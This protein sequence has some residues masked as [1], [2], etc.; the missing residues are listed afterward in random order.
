MHAVQLNRADT[1]QLINRWF[2]SKCGKLAVDQD[3]AERCCC[4]RLCEKEIGKDDFYGDTQFP[5]HKTCRAELDRQRELQ[6]FEKAEKL[7]QWT[8]PVYASGLGYSDGYFDFVDSLQD[9]CADEEDKLPDYVWCCTTDKCCP[10]ADHLYEMITERVI[11]NGWDEME[12][13]DINGTD[14]LYEALKVFVAANEKLVCW[15]IDTSRAL[16]LKPAAKHSTN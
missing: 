16:L 10:T 15:N 11:E 3:V 5:E 4:C 7:E 1:G 8:G 13:D 14:E 6:R 9:W 2:C 12:T